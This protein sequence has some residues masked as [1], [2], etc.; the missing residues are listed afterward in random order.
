MPIHVPQA[1]VMCDPFHA[2]KVG[3][4]VSPKP[5]NFS[6]VECSKHVD[7]LSPLMAVLHALDMRCLNIYGMNNNSIKFSDFQWKSV[8]N[9]KAQGLLL[10][11][12]LMVQPLWWRVRYVFL[13]TCWLCSLFFF[14]IIDQSSAW[15]LP[16]EMPTSVI[17]TWSWLSNWT[18]SESGKSWDIWF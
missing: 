1:N 14:S 13:T 9:G 17:A 16:R 4:A 15:Y 6:V 11:H 10:D 5:C 3:W 2:S 8:V 12:S 7:R 18:T